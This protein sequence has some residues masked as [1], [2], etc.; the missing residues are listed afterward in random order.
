[1]RKISCHY[2]GYEIGGA[3]TYYKC[4][5]NNIYCYYCVIDSMKAGTSPFCEHDDKE[6]YFLKLIEPIDAVATVERDFR[7]LLDIT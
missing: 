1:M 3:E 6:G 5:C 2:C 7:Y 4:D